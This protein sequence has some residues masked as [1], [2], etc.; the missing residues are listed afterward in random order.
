[1]L[2]LMIVDDEA[3]IRNGISS[4]VDW[5]GLGIE[6]VGE[7]ANGRDALNRALLLRPDIVITDIKMPL[8]SGLDFARELLKKR[9]DTRIVLLTGY[10][11]FSYMQQAIQM[12]A[13]DYLLKPVQ[14]NDL[15]KLMRRLC[16]EIRAQKEYKLRQIATQQVLARNLPV[17]RGVCL[18]DFMAGR[19]TAEAFRRDAEGL[20]IPL[21][22]PRH[23]AVSLDI[24]DWV[25]TASAAGGHSLARYSVLNIAEELLGEIGGTAFGYQLAESSL[26]GLV[27]LEH[28]EPEDI[29]EACRQI[30][31][32]THRF[33]HFTVTAAVGPCAGTMEQLRLSL[34]NAHDALD[35]KVY[36]GKNQVIFAGELPRA[37]DGQIVLL[38]QQDEEA[39][40]EALSMNKNM[41]AQKKLDEIFQGYFS[42]GAYTGKA[43]RQFGIVLLLL[44]LRVLADAQI[45]PEEAFGRGA[46]IVEEIERY[47]T[48][49]EI[50][51]FVKNI[52]ARTIRALDGRNGSS[53]RH[54]VRDSMAYVQA[55]YT[56]N[57]QV[58]DVA[59]AVYVTPN[60]FSKIFK[61]ETGENFTE[62]LNKFR[63]KK[64]KELILQ[65]PGS[66]VYEI[67]AKVG[68]N[69]YKYFSFIFKKYTGYTPGTFKELNR[70]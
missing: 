53:Y 59:A 46:H 18:L 65:E 5:P 9:P 3:V 42:G 32:Y 12:G 33:F 2:K 31:F 8:I 10:S 55:H 63:I 60:Y 34:R 67:A 44:A 7:A 17:M 45:P 40:Q 19:I 28:G 1:M 30:Q 62:W 36:T 61:Q 24:D 54:I 6:V 29:M 26:L 69:D 37:Q 64:A 27:C 58:S 47:E 38:A 49:D 21:A 41:A 57:I 11:D 68:F 51:L 48:L 20:Q 23:I 70:P 52:Y 43:V 22:G 16:G 56:E 50:R 15:E 14:V 25:H 35:R 66:R 4:I 13:V 39:L